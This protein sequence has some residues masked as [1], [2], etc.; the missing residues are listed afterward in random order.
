MSK[1]LTVEEVY[2]LAKEA[3][4]NPDVIE[5]FKTLA[6][7]AVHGLAEACCDKLS[8][9]ISSG[10]LI[11]HDGFFVGFCAAREGQAEPVEFQQLGLDPTGEWA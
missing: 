2:S 9:V 8:M 4:V 10:P 1:Q 11:D 6:E 3:G 5:S 7:E